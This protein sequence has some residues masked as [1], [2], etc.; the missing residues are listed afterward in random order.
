MGTIVLTYKYII[1]FRCIIVQIPKVEVITQKVHTIRQ[2]KTYTKLEKRRYVPSFEW[3][4]HFKS[5]QKPVDKETADY[6]AGKWM[7]K[8]PPDPPERP[9]PHEPIFQGLAYV[10]MVAANTY[11]AHIECEREGYKYCLHELET[12]QGVCEDIEQECIDADNAE[13]A[14]PDFTLEIKE[15]ETRLCQSAINDLIKW[16][17]QY[18]QHLRPTNEVVILSGGVCGKSQAV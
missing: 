9:T 17:N 1:M 14:T 4:L 16:G 15:L 7:P 10:R 11:L 8:L 2:F 12:I 18:N 6:Y 13:I 5:K 3:G